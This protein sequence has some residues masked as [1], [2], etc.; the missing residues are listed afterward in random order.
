MVHHVLGDQEFKYGLTNYLNQY[1]YSNADRNQL[2]DSFNGQN[3]PENTT[4]ADIMDG[5]VRQPGFPVITAIV[6]YQEHKIEISQKRFVLNGAADDST[7]WVPISITNASDPRFNN[8]KPT[9]WLSNTTQP[10]IVDV[11]LDQWVILNVNQT[12]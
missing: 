8:T 4:L 10:L 6:K 12:G 11:I 2:W 7:W 9:Y 1:K 5:W 3:L